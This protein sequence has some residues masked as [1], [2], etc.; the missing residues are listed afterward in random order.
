MATVGHSG[1]L[2]LLESRA[3]SNAALRR[4][5]SVAAW[6]VSFRVLSSEEKKS[7]A[8]PSVLSRLHCAWMVRMAAR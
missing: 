6:T 4:A 8:S 7:E 1:T 2:L 5:C 3:G